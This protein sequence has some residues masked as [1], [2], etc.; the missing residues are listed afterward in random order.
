MKKRKLKIALFIFLSVIGLIVGIFFSGY[1]NLLLSGGS[2]DDISALRPA[3]LLRGLASDE[4]H[5]LL[6]LGVCFVLVAGIAALLLTSRRET[7][8]SDTRTVAGGGIQTPVAVGQG[9][10]GTARWL[11]PAERKK[12]FAI[13][14][15]AAEEHI[16][17]KLLEDGAK[18]M[19]DVINYAEEQERAVAGVSAPDAAAGSRGPDVS[20]NAAF[21]VPE[22]VTTEPADK[23]ER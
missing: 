7:F 15:L 13:Y 19:K 5:R 23:G 4:R 10:H 21:A 1:V 22:T 17:S 9:Q 3:P 12:V 6:T 16:F 18:D 8:E 14:S 2:I 11:K 20:A